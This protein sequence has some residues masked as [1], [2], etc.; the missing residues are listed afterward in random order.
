MKSIKPIIVILAMLLWSCV[1][2]AAAPAGTIYLTDTLNTQ[3]QETATFNNVNF[4][5]AVIQDY[6]AGRISYDPN[7]YVHLMDTGITDVRIQIGQEEVY[8]VYN[9]TVSQIDNGKVCYASGVDATNNV[10]TVALADNSAFNTSA[11]VLG[12]ATHDIGVDELGLVT[13]RGIV[14]DFDTTGISA[15]LSFLGTGGDITSTKPLYPTNRIMTGSILKSG[16]L[17]G[18]Y[19]VSIMSLPRRNASRTYV[20]T[21]ADASAGTHYRAGYY[22]WSTTS[23]VLNQGSLSVTYGTDNRSKAAHVG[24]VPSAA[25]SVDT[26]QVG[27][28][29]TGTLDSETGSQTADQTAII[30][31]D[32]TTL[33]VDVMTESLEK[34][35]GDVVISLYT[36]SGSPSAY[37]LTINYGYSKYEDFTNIDGTVSA[38]SAVWEAGANESTFDIA[39]KHHSPN[40]WTYAASGFEPGNGNICNRQTDQAI[41]PAIASGED[42][43]YKR[44]NLATFIDGSGKEGIIIEIITGST[45]SIRNMDIHVVAYSEEL[46]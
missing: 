17:D 39:L 26:G 27:L 5:T 23:V 41:D 45:L 33:T 46:F 9:D 42:G 37:S 32:I 35:S 2:H 6:L 12:L 10:L 4:A 25:G 44:V 3:A 13:Y 29:V 28:N 1:G 14:R 40:G 19:M 22:D 16:V 36:V 31:D 20:F 11:Q 7:S 8:L 18:Q 34:F 43:A 24:V 21:S 30:T 15:G 38:F